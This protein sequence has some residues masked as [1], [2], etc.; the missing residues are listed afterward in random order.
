MMLWIFIMLFIAIISIITFKYVKRCKPGYYGEKC[1]RH[2][3][4]DTCGAN[5]KCDED[6]RCICNTKAK[7]MFC[8]ECIGNFKGVLCDTCITDYYGDKCERHCDSTT[9]GSN[10][11]C[12]DDGVCRCR[13]TY[14]GE[15][16]ERQCD[17]AANTCGDNG[18]CD[19]EGKCV[20]KQGY[21]GEKCDVYCDS[22]G[23]NGK[24][25]KDGKCECEEGYY[26][27]KCDV[28]CDSCGE[29]KECDKTGKCVCKEGY[30]GEKCDT[31]CDATTCGNRGTCGMDGKCICEPN[32]YGPYCKTYCE[33]K[34]CKQGCGKDGKCNTFPFELGEIEYRTQDKTQCEYGLNSFYDTDDN[35]QCL[36]RNEDI[37]YDHPTIK[38]FGKADPFNL[39]CLKDSILN[40]FSEDNGFI[41]YSCAKSSV[42]LTCRD[43]IGKRAK[44]EKD[45]ALQS[46]TDGTFTCCKK[47]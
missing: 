25:G 38:S 26:G 33:E 15:K 40:D 2:C 36:K 44:C 10:G 16:C 24:C 39:S 17:D 8:D 4:V 22:C 34:M 42:P 7:G 45:E 14:Y 46:V 9:C 35:L 29:H 21:H 19:K 41:Q 5:G 11:E 1:E 3:N 28:K 20:C 6:G 30:Y 47:S 37:D 23:V 32:W 31:Y 27:E 18:K 43:V 12:G 13:P